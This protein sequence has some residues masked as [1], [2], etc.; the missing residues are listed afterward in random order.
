MYRQ[1]LELLVGLKVLVEQV[2]VP[3]VHLVL[4]PLPEP[5]EN[6]QPPVRL[7]VPLELLL[8]QLVR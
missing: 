3:L 4:L 2:L 7:E 5:L 1:L 8:V 6:L